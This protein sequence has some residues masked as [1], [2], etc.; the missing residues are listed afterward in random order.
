MPA[1]PITPTPSIEAA[2]ATTKA[3][4]AAIATTKAL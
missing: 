4:E 3:I 1:I 2:T